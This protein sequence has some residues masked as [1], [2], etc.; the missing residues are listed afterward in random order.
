MAEG[1]RRLFGVLIVLAAVVGAVTLGGADSGGGAY[2]RSS[3]PTTV[4]AGQAALEPSVPTTATASAAE[5]STTS[6]GP[7]TSTT[8]L[9][10]AAAVST[11]TAPAPPATPTTTAVGPP[12][13]PATTTTTVACRNSANPACGPFRFE[14]QPG[15]DNPMF[16]HIVV[17]PPSP[18]AGQE[19]EFTVT[20]TDPD[21]VS[22]AGSTYNWGDSGIGES[23][24]DPCEKY[25]PWDPPARDPARATEVLTLRHTYAQP[26]TYK[27][28]F[29][30]TGDP[31]D[32]VD[33]VT[34]CGD[35][36]YASSASGTVTIEVR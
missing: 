30:F 35:R 31:F 6:T 25:G 8:R 14:P 18:V 19:V 36:P 15:P 13:P 34:G 21:G 12:P 29:F 26:G 28:V 24:V 5:P 23:S 16:V 10:S 4:P 22:R 11:T 33:S 9:V 27:V 3:A 1:S 32:C 7:A 2:I 17:G 20:L